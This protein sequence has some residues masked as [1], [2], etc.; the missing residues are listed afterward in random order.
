MG[1]T[2]TE[3]LRVLKDRNW[4]KW[5]TVSQSRKFKVLHITVCIYSC[6]CTRWELLDTVLRFS[7][8]RVR[9]ARVGLF[10]TLRLPTTTRWRC[11]QWFFISLK[12][13]RTQKVLS[14]FKYEFSH[15]VWVC[16]NINIHFFHSIVTTTYIREY[17]NILKN[18]KNRLWHLYEINHVKR[19][20]MSKVCTAS[21]FNTDMY[22]YQTLKNSN[23]DEVQMLQ[24]IQFPVTSARLHLRYCIR[25]YRNIF[26]TALFD[27]ISKVLWS[28]LKV[29]TTRASER[30]FN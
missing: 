11:Q 12:E 13:T 25:E 28:D 18:M 2:R 26:H 3:C 10:L 30:N 1:K 9:Y 24:G 7:F 8:H 27:D 17:G 20:R 21:R 5:E 22:T 29:V 4:Q 6:I 16:D 19:G 15:K 23:I 14:N